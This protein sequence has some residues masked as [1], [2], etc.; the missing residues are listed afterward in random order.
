MSIKKTIKAA[1]PTVNSVSGYVLSWDVDIT[2]REGSFEYNYNYSKDVANL[3]KIPSDFSE[4]EVLGY[5]PEGLEDVFKHHKEFL[6]GN[7][8]SET[9]IVDDFTFSN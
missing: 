1:R 8:S 3:N 5:M 9:I 7:N 2:L 4:P 6:G